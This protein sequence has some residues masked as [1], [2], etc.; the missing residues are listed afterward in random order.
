MIK[1]ALIDDE[2]TIIDLYSR[3]LSKDFIVVTA[4]NG[5]EGIALIEKEKPALVIADIR[6]PK[7]DGIKMIEEM[8]RK[9]MNIP[10]IIMTNLIEDE[11]M[12]KAIEMGVTHYFSKLQFTPAQVLSKVHEV[13]KY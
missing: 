1:I 3:V 7:V 11:K 12:A 6:M 9:K 5:E 8:K 2:P 10:V 4:Y 13:L